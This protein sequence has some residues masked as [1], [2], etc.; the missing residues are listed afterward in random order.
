VSAWGR[1]RNE[2]VLFLCTWRLF[3]S[4]LVHF[5]HP[6]FCRLGTGTLNYITHIKAT[7][8]SMFLEMFCT[9]EAKFE[10]LQN[11]INW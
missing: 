3:L 6:L 1:R 10:R 11:L 4:E 8:L 7:V 9:H 2:Y 5:D